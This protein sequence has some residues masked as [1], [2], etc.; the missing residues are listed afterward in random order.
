MYTTSFLTISD[1]EI[2]ILKHSVYNVS[3]SEKIKA[4]NLI[5]FFSSWPSKLI[6][7]TTNIFSSSLICFW[8]FNHRV[9]CKLVC[10]NKVIIASHSPWNSDYCILFLSFQTRIR[11]WIESSKTTRVKQQLEDKDRARADWSMFVA[12]PTPLKF[13]NNPHVRRGGMEKQ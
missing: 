6:A 7:H 3:A 13:G 2:N 12:P 1:G 5:K 11:K 9:E 10:I 4:R 8:L